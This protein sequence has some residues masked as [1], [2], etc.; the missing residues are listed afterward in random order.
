MYQQLVRNQ[1]LKQNSEP[2]EDDEEEEKVQAASR[3][4][5]SHKRSLREFEKESSLH[6]QFSK[7]LL[8]TS[9]GDFKIISYGES[10]KQELPELLEGE[11]EEDK[12]RVSDAE[13]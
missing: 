11:K 7:R 4:L 1:P 13:H 9:Q 8:L 3:I 10:L 12:E 5:N 2:E 6:Q